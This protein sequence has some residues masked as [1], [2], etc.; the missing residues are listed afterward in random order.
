M[1]LII[2]D[3]TLSTPSAN[4]YATTSYVTTFCSNLGLSSWATA[5]TANREAAILRGMAYIDSL[6]YVGVKSTDDQ[7]LK[8]PRMNA[9][10]EDGY[11][12][13]SGSIPSVLK[14]GLARAAY[15]ENA[16]PGCLQ[17][18]L[19]KDDFITQEKIDVISITYEQGTGSTVFQA[20]QAYLSGLLT[21]TSYAPI[22]RT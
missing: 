20:I 8:W 13:D 3:G 21:S 1:A 10:D 17:P 4:T 11:A 12:I 5:S 7:P 2:E 19:T 18:N 22:R 14:K 6:S 16:D 15:E 9:Y